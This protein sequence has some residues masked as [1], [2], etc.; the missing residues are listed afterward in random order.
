VRRRRFDTALRQL[1]EVT[2]LQ[3]S[4]ARSARARRTGDAEAEER[5]YEAYR[6]EI[7][8][9]EETLDVPRAMPSPEETSSQV[10]YESVVLP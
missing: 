3:A 6:A 5:L 8:F 4:L 1:D 10:S 2:V 9:L 7:A